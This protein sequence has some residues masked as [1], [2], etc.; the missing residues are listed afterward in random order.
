M[1]VELTVEKFKKRFDESEFDAVLSQQADPDAT[2]LEYL[3]QVAADVVSRVNV[4]RR[5]RG[6]LP[7]TPPAYYVPPGSERHAYA[8]AQFMCGINLPSLTSLQ[9]ENRNDAATK[10]EDHLKDLAACDA[11]GDDEWADNYVTAT[12]SSAPVFGGFAHM[13]FVT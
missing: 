2:V 9:G 3:R 5:S 7:V 13:D 11:D 1:W 4:C 10:A 12:T 6:L 8:L